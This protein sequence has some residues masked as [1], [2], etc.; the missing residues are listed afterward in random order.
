MKAIRV[1]VAATP[2]SAS[3][4]GCIVADGGDHHGRYAGHRHDWRHW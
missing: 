4:S 2:M 3:V 1:I